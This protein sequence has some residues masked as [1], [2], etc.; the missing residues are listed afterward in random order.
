MLSGV[1]KRYAQH[2]RDPALRHAKQ[3]IGASHLQGTGWYISLAANEL[4][5]PRLAD[6]TEQSRQTP[7]KRGRMLAQK[8]GQVC[9]GDPLLQH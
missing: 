2:L 1:M 5:E 8:I 6:S 9:L 4:H 3:E 7:A